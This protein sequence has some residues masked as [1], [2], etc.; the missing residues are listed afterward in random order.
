M[1][2]DVDAAR[3][4]VKDQ[5][6][7][8][9]GQ[10][11]REDGLL[12][13]AAGQELDGSV[14]IGR[15]DVQR[16][17]IARGDGVGFAPGDGAGPA[18][19]R[20]QSQHDVLAQGQIADDAVGLAFLGAHAKALGDGGLGRG[21]GD[22]LAVHHGV[23]AVGPV[24][25]EHQPRSFRP[26]RAEQACDAHHLARPDRQIE[27][28]N[29]AALAVIGELEGGGRIRGV[30][31]GI[32]AGAMGGRLGQI[33]AQ[34]QCHQIAARQFG[35]GAAADHATI[36]QHRHAVG[37]LIDLIQKVGDD[38]NAKPLIAQLFQHGEQGLHLAR[39]KAGCGFVQ[40]QHLARQIDRAGDGDD[41]AHGHGIVRQGF[42]GI[43]RDA[44]AG[45][46]GGGV[47]PHPAMID[48]PHAARLPAQIQVLGHGQIVEQVHLLIDGADAKRLRLGDRARLDLGPG[49]RHMARI[50]AI[51]AGQDLD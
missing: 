24:D 6:A 49:Q 11:A 10:P 42:V 47:A 46:Q 38:D 27:G 51:G 1:G 36:A 12:L 7:R 45:Q 5:E 39:V 8:I 35:N 41:L 18:A 30:R 28:R 43:G 40:K 14:G 17:D 20:L 29:R 32:P 33:A 25:A 21:Q 16:L 26:P 19:S 4:L 22:G 23:A 3:R 13:V 15:A 2:A 44:I 34:H 48:Q 9:G 31:R 37:D 50:A